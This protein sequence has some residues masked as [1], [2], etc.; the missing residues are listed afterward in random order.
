M[1]SPV[2]KINSGERAQRKERRERGAANGKKVRAPLAPASLPI[3]SFKGK[4]YGS[5]SWPHL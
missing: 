1:A 5:R 3:A 2:R 4:H